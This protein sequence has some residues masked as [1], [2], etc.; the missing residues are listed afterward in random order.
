MLQVLFVRL[1]IYLEKVN[2]LSVT[3]TLRL[4]NE[5]TAIPNLCP[6]TSGLGGTMH[7]RI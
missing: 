7:V 6:T 2:K 3:T 1:K 5:I 4:S